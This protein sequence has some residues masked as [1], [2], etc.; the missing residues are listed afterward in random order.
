MVTDTLDVWFDSGSSHLCVMQQRG[1]GASTM[2]GAAFVQAVQE[3]AIPIAA[4]DAQKYATIQL[5]NLSNKQQT[6]LQNAAT[7]AAM[8]MRNAD[9][10]TKAAIQNSLKILEEI[11]WKNGFYRKDIGYK[12][13]QE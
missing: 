7:Y 10:K 13:I 6:A 5:Q 9:A 4:A 1:L 11:N 2:A 12:V 3:S 8:D